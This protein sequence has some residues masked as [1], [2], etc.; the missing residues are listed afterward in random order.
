MTEA[1]D[2]SA[3]AGGRRSAQGADSVALEAKRAARRASY[4]RAKPRQEAALLR[5]E[6]GDLARLD[7]ACARAGLS[8]SSFAKLYLLPAAEAIARRLADIDAARAASRLSLE[9]F[10]ARA[11]DSQL[12]AEGREPSAPVGA[13]FDSLF[14]SKDPPC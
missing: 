4:R 5:L 9:S 10:L 7:Q 3:S 2:A 12:E 8:R 6:K 1:I 14:A 13:E 11:L